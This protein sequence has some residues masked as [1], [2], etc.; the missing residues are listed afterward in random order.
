MGDW[1][2]TTIPSVTALNFP[3]FGSRGSPVILR[4][5]I[6]LLLFRSPP[7]SKKQPGRVFRYDIDND[8]LEMSPMSGVSLHHSALFD[9]NRDSFPEVLLETSA[10]GNYKT[11]VPFCDQ[12]AWL[13][14]LEI[15]MDYLFGPV[16][17]PGYP[18]IREKSAFS[19]EISFCCSHMAHPVTDRVAGFP[20]SEIPGPQAIY[21]PAEDQRITD[22]QPEEPDRSPFYFQYLIDLSD[23]VSCDNSPR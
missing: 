2:I 9:L 20:D 12:S 16:E 3:K 22:S 10:T 13:M 8:R 11:S 23:H 21:Y 4:A 5:Q 6:I 17:F 15:D 18:F 19:S 7:A 14:V 1:C